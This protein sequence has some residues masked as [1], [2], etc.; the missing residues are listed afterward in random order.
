MSSVV[1]ADKLC[2]RA[3]YVHFPKTAEH[4]NHTPPL[5]GLGV[6]ND[7]QPF[8]LFGF[9]VTSQQKQSTVYGTEDLLLLLAMFHSIWV[10]VDRVLVVVQYLEDVLPRSGGT[11]IWPTSPQRLHLLR[12]HI[13]HLHPSIYPCSGSICDVHIPRRRYGCLEHEQ[14]Y[15]FHRE[16]SQ[17]F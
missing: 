5:Y 9:I 8:E 17:R 11:C 16:E 7:F 4:L 10:D 14:S 2:V 12:G 3:E 13:R 1:C 6:H 15:G